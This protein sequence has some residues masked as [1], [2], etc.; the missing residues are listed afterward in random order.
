MLD[1]WRFLAP[2][3]QRPDV[4]GGQ[5]QLNLPVRLPDKTLDVLSEGILNSGWEGWEEKLARAL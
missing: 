3:N 5:F 1:Q 2:E 4:D